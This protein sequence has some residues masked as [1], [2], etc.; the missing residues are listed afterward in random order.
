M[1]L[2]RM[3]VF[4]IAFGLNDVIKVVLDFNAQTIEFF[5]NNVSQ[6]I[7]FNTLNRPVCPAVTFAGVHCAVR[8]QNI[9]NLNTNNIP[10]QPFFFEDDY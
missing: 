7:A 4:F 9:Q 6:G 8:I 5:R 10:N 1:T 3:F 2:T